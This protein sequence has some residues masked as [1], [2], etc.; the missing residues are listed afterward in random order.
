M[1]D[2]CSSRRYRWKAF[3]SAGGAAPAVSRAIGKTRVV[4]FAGVCK[5]IDTTTRVCTVGTC[6][7]IALDGRITGLITVTTG[8]IQ[9]THTGS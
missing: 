1:K 9:A 3:R 8:F 5:A 4:R 7:T 6:I 2:R